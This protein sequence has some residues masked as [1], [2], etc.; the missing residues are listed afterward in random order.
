MAQ[1]NNLTRFY[2]KP[3][4]ETDKFIFVLSTEVFI[5]G[6]FCA[7]SCSAR[8]V[9]YLIDERYNIAMDDRIYLDYFTEIHKKKIEKKN[10]D[11]LFA[12]LKEHGKF[13][14]A[15]KIQTHGINLGGGI[16]KF[17]EVAKAA[18]ANGIVVHRADS[19]KYENINLFISIITPEEVFEKF[20]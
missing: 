20:L 14:T 11:Y 9:D 4:K 17:V 15:K 1:M 3:Q 12:F 2:K 8:L 7:E 16:L 19:L 18:E 5:E 13:V 6:V 10:V